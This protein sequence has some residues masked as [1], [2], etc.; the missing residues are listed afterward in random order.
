[1]IVLFGGEKGGSGKTTIA[2]NIAAIR[3]TV[4]SDVLLIDTDRQSTASFWCGVREDK[5][6]TPRV[7]SVQKYD[8]AVRTEVKERIKKEDLIS[9]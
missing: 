9:A 1:M 5:G 7:A 6:I 4:S 3:T 8:K 2:T